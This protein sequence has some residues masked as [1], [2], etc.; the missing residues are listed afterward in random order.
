MSNK[1]KVN[2]RDSLFFYSEPS[3]QVTLAFESGI[4]SRKFRQT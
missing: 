3:P 1:K 2:I 4:M